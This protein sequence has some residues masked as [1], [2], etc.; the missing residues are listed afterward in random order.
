MST[1]Y[2]GVS[3]LVSAVV[4]IAIVLSAMIMYMYFFSKSRYA[5]VTSFRDIMERRVKQSSELLSILHTSYYGGK[6][7]I[8]VFN[9]GYDEVGITSVYV[10]D[11]SV[12]YTIKDGINNEV[13]DKI[14]VGRPYIIEIDY[15]ISG[16][17][18]VTII[19]T[20]SRVYTVTVYP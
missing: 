8:F 16:Q 18:T 10:G 11:V 2:K 4:L 14:G 1:S 15:A 19:T 9:Y 17:T 5:E 13:V 20:S 3:E 6:I 12:S 7:M